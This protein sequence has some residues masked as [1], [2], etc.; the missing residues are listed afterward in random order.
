MWYNGAG[1]Y[2]AIEQ[3]RKENPELADHLTQ[4]ADRLSAAAMANY[5]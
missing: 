1:R 4:V 3:K 2:N 5:L